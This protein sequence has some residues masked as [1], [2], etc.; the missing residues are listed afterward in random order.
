MNKH[1]EL[2]SFVHAARA[3]G[4]TDEF[5]VAMLREKG[6]PASDVYAVFAQRYAAQTGIAFPE[7]PGR[8][9]AAREAFFHLLAFATLGMWIFAIGSI[10]FDLIEA[11]VPDATVDRNRFALGQASSQLASIIVAFPAFLWATRS[12][13]S[14]QLGNPDKAESPVRRWVSNLGLLLTSLVFMGDLIVFVTSLLQGELTARVALRCIVVV[15]LA[16]AVFLYYSRGLGKSRVLPP[17]T[18]HRTF[19]VCASVIMAVTLGLGFWATGSPS[20]VRI[21]S[22]DARR[23]RDLYDITVQVEN[24]KLSNGLKEPSMTLADIGMAQSDPFSRRP[25]EY[26]RLDEKRYRLCA[27]FGAPS[28]PVPG[29]AAQFWRHPAGRQ[30]F[31][32]SFDRTP[33]MPPSYYR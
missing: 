13:L 7:P 26:Q 10:W 19:A 18:W 6:W 21:V 17:M 16:G 30:C 28:R 31:D 12:I 1:S 33:P 20:S 14:D 32:I 2:E 9:E 29:P 24:K 3:Q 25:Y 11:W 27:E 5:L 4:A 15:V 23:L 8:L 22:E